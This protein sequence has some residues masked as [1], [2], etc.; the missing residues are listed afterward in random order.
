MDS[1]NC[2]LVPRRELAKDALNLL[3]MKFQRARQCGERRRVPACY[4]PLGNG[5]FTS[6]AR[7]D[8]SKSRV[9]CSI[10]QLERAGG[11]P[12]ALLLLAGL[13][14]WAF[15]QADLVGGPVQFGRPCDFCYSGMPSSQC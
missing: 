11:N 8:P 5:S 4:K 12:R 14:I 3:L 2:R 7:R 1:S 6:F 10:S 9:R 13:G 15:S